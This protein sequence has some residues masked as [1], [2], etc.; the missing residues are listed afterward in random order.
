MNTV[1]HIAQQLQS[2]IRR[3]EWAQAQRLPGQRQL[4]ESLGVSRASLREAITMLEGLGLVRSEAGRGVFIARPGE[5]GLGSAYGR[6]RFQGRYALRDVYLVRCELEELAA[7]LA[8]GVVTRH[9]LARLRATVRQMEAGA[10]DGDLVTMAEGDHA[11]HAAIYEIAGSPLL[12]DIA[13]NIGDIVEG[14]RQV[15]FADPARVREPIREH[16]AIIEALASGVPEQA[17]RA[18]R[19]HIRNVADRTGLTLSL[20]GAKPTTRAA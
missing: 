10:A 1:E 14:S 19:A 17:R 3:G 18:M 9:G 16:L 2:R 7:A 13:E 5:R 8:A 11:F 4:A 15:A 6:W 12:L 20:S